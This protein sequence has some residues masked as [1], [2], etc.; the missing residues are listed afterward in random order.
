MAELKG[1]AGRTQTQVDSTPSVEIPLDFLD[2]PAKEG[3]LGKIGHY[4][5]TEVV[6]RGGFYVVLKAFD[7]VLHRVVAI[8]VLAPQLATSATARRP[9]CTERLQRCCVIEPTGLDQLY[10]VWTPIHQE[11]VHLVTT[12]FP[13]HPVCG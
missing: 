10:L 2:P 4:E 13:G 9:I 1:K 7:T 8:K 12:K 5:V 3:Q 11:L 6:G